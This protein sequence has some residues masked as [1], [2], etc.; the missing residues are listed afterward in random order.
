MF[1]GALV[2]S[3]PAPAAA[4]LLEIEKKKKKVTCFPNISSAEIVS[5]NMC[6]HKEIG[7]GKHVLYFLATLT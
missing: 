4:V 7:L 3:L 6:N 1:C 2:A 5:G